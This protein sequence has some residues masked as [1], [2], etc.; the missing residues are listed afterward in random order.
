MLLRNIFRNNLSYGISVIFQQLK[1][2]LFISV[3]FYLEML[4][5]LSHFFNTMFNWKYPLEYI[6]I[7]LAEDFRH[8]MYYYKLFRFTQ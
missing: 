7:R 1:D 3:S 2:C 5:L 8:H 4:A 6:L